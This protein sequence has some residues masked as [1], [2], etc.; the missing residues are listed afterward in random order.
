MTLTPPSSP[1]R[2]QDGLRHVLRAHGSRWIRRV[3]QPH[4]RAHQHRHHS[5]QQLRG[6]QRRQVLPSCGD[7][8]AGH[9]GPAGADS[10]GWPVRLPWALLEQVV[11]RGRWYDEHLGTVCRCRRVL[12]RH[13]RTW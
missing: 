4:G 3:L 8:P 5:L 13:R 7:G 11:S 10:P 1:G 6:D 12:M 9:A 2:R